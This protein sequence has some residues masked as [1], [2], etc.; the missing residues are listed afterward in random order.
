[1]GKKRAN[2]EGS[3]RRLPSGNWSGQIMIGYTSEGKRK[4][5]S[6]TAPTKAEV[7][8]KVREYVE[9]HGADKD[10]DAVVS[11]SEWADT[12]YADHR[13]QVEEST[14][15]SYS[16]TLNTLKR[17]FQDRPIDSIKQ[18]DINRFIDSL[19]A[20]GRSRSTIGKCKSMLVQ[21]FSAAED[22]ELIA[23]NPAVRAKT[24][25]ADKTQ[26]YS[27][28][29]FLPHEVETLK[30]TLPNDLLGNSI[31]SL[32]GTG[33]RLQELLALTKEDIAQDGSLVAVNKAVKMAYRQPRIGSTK[34]VKG[35]RVIPIP[36]AFRTY[37]MYLR[38][39]GGDPY[40]WT[41]SERE[42]GLYT[43]EEF[44]S[45]Y[46][47]LMRHIPGVVYRSPHCCRHTYITMLQ[48]KQVPM[49]LISALAGHS[50]TTTTLGY[51]HVTLDTLK[52][53]IESL[54]HPT[55]TIMNEENKNAE[56]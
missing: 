31:L 47:R 19:A 55:T 30:E 39:H 54:D 13:T 45:K 33:M 25:K 34:S 41:N 12:W 42:N 6:F 24:I 44:R 35:N 16:F 53:V 50:D 17:Y 14:Y 48:A 26:A 40:I 38:E 20:K 36:A 3:Y 56:I 43:I 32:I 23:K 4:I 1:M 11:F 29:A 51:T 28:A 49:D 52:K 37:V 5:K 21:I 27:R 18:L 8:V 22:N 10:G 9:T 46:N 15:W 7:Q 2:H